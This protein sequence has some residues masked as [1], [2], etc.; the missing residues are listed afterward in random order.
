MSDIGQGF[1]AALKIMI[2]IGILI[3]AFVGFVLTMLA[4]WMGWL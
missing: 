4:R 2:A 3:G 1:A